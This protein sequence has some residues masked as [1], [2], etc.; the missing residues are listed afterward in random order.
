MPYNIQNPY[1][2]REMNRQ[3]HQQMSNGSGYGNG[4]AQGNNSR[5]W[6][7]QP[8][9]NNNIEMPAAGSRGRNQ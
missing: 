4:F 7:N 2:L 9:Q 8:N 1:I 5:G 6:N 3:Q